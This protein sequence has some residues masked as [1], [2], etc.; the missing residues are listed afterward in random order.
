MA[1]K[2][3]VTAQ[4]SDKNGGDEEKV[5]PKYLIDF[6]AGTTSGRS[7]P[8]LIASRRC[9]LDQQADEDAPSDAD[10]REFIDRITEH[11]AA[12]R[13]YLLA[14]TPL[15]EAIFR[16][17]LANGNEPMDAEAISAVLTEKWAMTPFPRNTDA[18][19]IGRMA[20][21]S[22]SYCI[23]RLPEPEPEPKIAVVKPKIVA[24][25]PEP[26]IAAV[27]PE[28]EPE[29]ADAEPEVADAEPKVA[30]TEPEPGPEIAEA[31]VQT[32]AES[33]EGSSEEQAEASS[34]DEE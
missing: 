20:D 28:P 30:D 25:E 6:E 7:L 34:T 21:N 26:E 5:L 18:D 12:E 1:Q 32:E 3:K 24:L 9:Y 11:C 13:D 16:V 22:R 15:K 14:D 17:L 33:P 29:V 10:P 2:V 27:E 8:M 19:V 23:A 4:V 31:P